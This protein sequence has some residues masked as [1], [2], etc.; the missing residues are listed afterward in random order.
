MEP[1]ESS[2]VEQVLREYSAEIQDPV[3]VRSSE[4]VLIVTDFPAI[5]DH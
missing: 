2:A 3:G 5:L 4:Y 1:Q